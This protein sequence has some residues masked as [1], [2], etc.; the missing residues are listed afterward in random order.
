MT[1]GVH[2]TGSEG[3]GASQSFVNLGLVDSF[4]PPGQNDA[5][6]LGVTTRMPKDL[7]GKVKR[8]Q[9]TGEGREVPSTAAQ[10][11]TC[12]TVVDSDSCQKYQARSVSQPFVTP[13]SCADVRPEVDSASIQVGGGAG[14]S[15]SLSVRSAEPQPLPHAAGSRTHAPTK[16]VAD[17]DNLLPLSTSPTNNDDASSL[18]PPPRLPLADAPPLR[19]AGVGGS[20][21]PG[22]SLSTRR[23]DVGSSSTACASLPR[24]LDLGGGGGCQ[25][26]SSNPG[27]QLAPSSPPP[28]LGGG[29]SSG[30]HSIEEDESSDFEKLAHFVFSQFADSKGLCPIFQDKP[31]G[32]GQED[33]VSKRKRT[34]LFPFRWSNP[35]RQSTTMVDQTVSERVSSGRSPILPFSLPGK[36]FYTT[37]GDPLAGKTSHVNSSL[38][39]LLPKSL[40]DV[41]PSFSTK[42][43]TQ[44]EDA[45]RYLRSVQNFQFWIFGAVSRLLKSG[46]STP[47]K[48]L[49]ANQAVY[50]MQLAMQR[51]AQVSTTA[52]S[53]V[54]AFRRQSILAS[55]IPP[56]SFAVADK[57]DLL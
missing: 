17:M 4:L 51:A 34:S 41:R 39:R 13:I 9:P 6:S 43:L 20:L 32:P 16:H 24:R 27:V 29:S 46:D 37:D 54:L 31:L 25:P 28:S 10:L 12:P 30:D 48:D 11:Q 52:L 36:S 44:M 8:S 42:D 19:V 38:A 1:S 21:L 49:L 26:S 15:C 47:D 55:L 18:P 45:L 2:L 22:G 35:M 50:S 40:M 53:N 5:S 56:P 7:R 3:M 57:Q 23:V 33:F 14:G